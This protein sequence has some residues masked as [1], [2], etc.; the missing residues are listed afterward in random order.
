[1]RLLKTLVLVLLNEVVQQSQSIL[2]R[3]HKTE[4]HFENLNSLCK[5]SVHLMESETARYWIYLPV[6]YRSSPRR[7]SI[8]KDVLKNFIKLTGKHLCI[9][10]FCAFCE[11]SKNTF[12]TE[13]LWA[14]DSACNMDPAKHFW[15]K[16]LRCSVCL[17][18][19]SLKV[20]SKMFG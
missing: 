17:K 13:H 7:C 9:G 6:V 18:L 5:S 14:T 15:W 1:M 10:F 8:K 3:H 12:F 16:L 19:F 4:S 11:I 2:S 20:S